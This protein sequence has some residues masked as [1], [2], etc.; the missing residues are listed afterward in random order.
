[1]ESTELT[2]VRSEL[3][4]SPSYCTDSIQEIRANAKK[5]PRLCQYSRT[6]A[7]ARMTQVVLTAYQFRNQSTDEDS[8]LFMANNLV[9][10]LA[11]D[12][13]GIGS[14]Y[15]TFEEI[16]RAVKKAILGQGREMFGISF[17]SL[18]AAIT[19]YIKGEGHRIDR[20]LRDSRR[21]SEQKSLK[22]SIIAPMLTAY[23]GALLKHST[24]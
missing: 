11:A 22:D 9:D 15:I 20:E 4:L 6:E 7:V 14:K 16:N 21:A 2:T 3:A 18:Y 23:S 12:M 1:M 17:A 5:H 19:D 8:I 10:E 13:D 24:K